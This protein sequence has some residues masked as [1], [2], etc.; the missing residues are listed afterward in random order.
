[1]KIISHAWRSYES[2]LVKIWMNQD[3]PFSTYKDL[4]EEDWARFVE[5][6][7]SENFATNSEYMQWLRSQ[8]KLGHHLGNTGYDGKQRK[9]QQE[10]EILAQV[11][12]HNPYDNFCG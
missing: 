11:G 8:N 3:T 12:L 9:W 5:N 10:N 7:E 1:M 6:C 4:S 2:K